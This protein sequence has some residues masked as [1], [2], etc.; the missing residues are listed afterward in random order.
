MKDLDLIERRLGGFKNFAGQ[1]NA[2]QS[3]GI[4]QI[5]LSVTK[6]G[7][8]AGLFAELF[9]AGASAAD[10]KNPAMGNYTAAFTFATGDL[11]FTYSAETV[12]ISCADRPYRHLLEF[13]K[14]NS[15]QTSLI[16][17]SVS[18][19]SQLAKK[20]QVFKK[21]AFGAD[22]TNQINPE[23]YRDPQNQQTNVI[24][25]DSKISIDNESGILLEFVAIAVT[26]NFSF[27]IPLYSKPNTYGAQGL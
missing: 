5:S 22:M 26:V 7:T 27:F 3:A 25:I 8:G 14:I 9:S 21:S 18:D 23:A 15:F 17:M 16:R 20:L 13:M 6:T 1:E 2:L 4:A 24:D 11:V 19:T 10:V 12:T